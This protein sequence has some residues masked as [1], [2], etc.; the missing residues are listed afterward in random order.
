[1]LALSTEMFCIRR[2]SGFDSCNCIE[3]DLQCKLNKRDDSLK[4]VLFDSQDRTLRWL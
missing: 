1:M 2:M 3:K 4:D